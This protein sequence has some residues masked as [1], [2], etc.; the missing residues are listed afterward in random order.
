MLTIDKGHLCVSHVAF[1]DC[2]GAPLN[3]G[4]RVGREVFISN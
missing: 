3:L 4:K 2:V 1:F